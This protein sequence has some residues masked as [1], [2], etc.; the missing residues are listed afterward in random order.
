MFSDDTTI[1]DSYTRADAINDGVL[2]DVSQRASE[3][4]FKWPVALTRAAWIDCVQWDNGIEQTKDTATGQDENGRL[5]DVLT[6]ALY[7]LRRA[8]G[9]H[10]N[11]T[12]FPLLRIPPT[13]SSAEPEFVKLKIHIGPGDTA[14]PVL[15]ISLPHED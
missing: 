2:I 11:F 10:A 6:V 9:N 14:A 13:G 8:R 5:H 1:I 4:G 12:L 3:S 7:A 15:T